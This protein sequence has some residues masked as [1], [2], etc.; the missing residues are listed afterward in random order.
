MQNLISLSCIN[1]VYKHKK[2]CSKNT[3]MPVKVN[4]VNTLTSRKHLT[5]SL[6]MCHLSIIFVF[7]SE[8]TGKSYNFFHMKLSNLNRSPLL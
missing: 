4:T 1:A 2:R 8:F 7:L 6:Q 3:I 5:S